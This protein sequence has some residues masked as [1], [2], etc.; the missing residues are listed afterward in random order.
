MV[1]VLI[2]I[3]GGRCLQGGRKYV[4]VWYPIFFTTKVTYEVLIAF[5]LMGQKKSYGYFSMSL[6]LLSIS[7]FSLHGKLSLNL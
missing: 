7:L 2:F 4:C 6:A 1:G 3:M 5:F